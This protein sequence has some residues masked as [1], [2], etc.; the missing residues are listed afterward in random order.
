MKKL[1]ILFI[2]F[3]LT[4]SMNTYA[5][6]P[7]ILTAGISLEK[8]PQDFYGTWRVKSVLVDTNSKIFKE[9]NTDIW[10]LYRQNNVINLEN[11]FS[12]AKASVTISELGVNY[13]KFTKTGNYD[14]KKL[15]DSVKLYL[16]NDTFTGYNDL[17][18]DS[19]NSEGHVYKSERATYKLTGEKIS[20]SSVR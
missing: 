20:G 12:G 17:K 9:K 6:Q 18:L 2:V 14:G 16:K 1:L 5:E 11:P 3:F 8:V 15:T 19:I 13:I 7:K 4:F 10:N